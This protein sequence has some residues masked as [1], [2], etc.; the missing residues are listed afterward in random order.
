MRIIAFSINPIFQEHISGGASKHLINLAEYLSS[1]GHDFTIISSQ[2]MD[3]P[4]SFIAPAGYLVKAVL[5]FH[6]PFPQPYAISPADLSYIYS[7]IA[8]EIKQADRLYIHDGELLLPHQF[9]KIPVITSF[10][11]NF[12][13]E[14]ILG[15]FLSQADEIIAVSPYSAQ[16]LRATAGMYLSGFAQRLHQ[17]NN[18]LDTALYQPSNAEELRRQLLVDCPEAEPIIVHPHRVEPGKGL[19]SAIDL[20]AKLVKMPEFANL[21]ALVPHGLDQMRGKDENQFL[22]FCKELIRSKGLEQNFIFH[23]WLTP[24]QMPAYYSLADLTV[25]LGTAPEAFGNVAYESL[26][27]GTPSLVYKI[28]THRSQLADDLLL[29]ARPLDLEDAVNQTVQALR[30]KKRVSEKDQERIAKHFSAKS[31]LEAYTKVILEAQIRPLLQFQ[32]PKDK[33]RLGLAPWVYHEDNALYHDYHARWYTERD[34]P[35]LER[36]L[37]LLAQ[38]GF[39]EDT[40]EWADF[41]RIGLLVPLSLECEA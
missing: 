10:R 6:Q 17:I 37:Q 33:R 15:S 5:P 31:Q 23:R 16:V 13:P 20:V 39:I 38:Y 24:D 11:D 27:C 41:K 18:G 1:L 4:Q 26:L 36:M 8:K 21:K 32:P 35:M 25:C 9:S 29:K 28:G 2:P 19:L 12:Y 7:R 34:L 14:S 3:G 22:S 40:P 30:A